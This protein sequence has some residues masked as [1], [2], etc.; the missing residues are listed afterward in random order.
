MTLMYRE[1]RDGCIDSMNSGQHAQDRSVPLSIHVVLAEFALSFSC[2]HFW[3]NHILFIVDCCRCCCCRYCC[4]FVASVVVVVVVVVVF[5][6]GVVVFVFCAAW[7]N[8]VTRLY[9]QVHTQSVETTEAHTTFGAT[10]AVAGTSHNSNNKNSNNVNNS[11]SNSNN[12]HHKN[13]QQ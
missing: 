1:H 13:E 5:V 9:L 11:N 8:H 3:V 10:T 4:C 7:L 12:S 2:E 6:I